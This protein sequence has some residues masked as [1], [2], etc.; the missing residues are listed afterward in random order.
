MF[1][2]RVLQR[3]HNCWAGGL[4]K[5]SS[6]SSKTWLDEAASQHLLV[7]QDTKAREIVETIAIHFA[8]KVSYK[9]AN[10]CRLQLLD[11][12]LGKQWYSF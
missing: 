12:G 1:E 11:G 7:T 9:V 8:E 3:E 2:L 4:A 6:C 5:F 10:N